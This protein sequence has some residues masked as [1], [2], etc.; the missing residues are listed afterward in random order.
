[1]WKWFSCLFRKCSDDDDEDI[2]ISPKP[3]IKIPPP[4][5]K[6]QSIDNKFSDVAVR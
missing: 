5:F 1:M 2:Q 6:Y 4:Y 3:I